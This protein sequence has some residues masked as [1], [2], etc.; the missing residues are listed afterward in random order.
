MESGE[1]LAER[2]L[3]RVHRACEFGVIA[4][5]RAAYVQLQRAC[6]YLCSIAQVIHPGESL[7]SELPAFYQDP[8]LHRIGTLSAARGQQPRP[9]T[10]L[11]SVIGPDGLG[12]AECRV[13]QHCEDVIDPVITW[14]YLV[15]EEVLAR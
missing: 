15:E 4:C 13:V 5:E 10:G 6:V 14:D 11:V 3:Q 9:S 8:Q 12:I 7:D 1:P 2:L